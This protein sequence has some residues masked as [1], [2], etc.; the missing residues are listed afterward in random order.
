MPRSMLRSMRL[1]TLVVVRRGRSRATAFGLHPVVPRDAPPAL[2]LDEL[3]ASAT[4]HADFRS[5]RAMR[6]RATNQS[7]RSD[8]VCS[9]REPGAA[10]DCRFDE[11]GTAIKASTDA[12][13][14]RLVSEAAAGVW[15]GFR[16]DRRERSK[17]AGRGGRRP[18]RR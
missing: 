1:D 7:G 13:D 5:A 6:E 11:V 8:V 18:R 10:G 2:A 16:A 14:A 17:G 4:R 12:R 3:G 9:G 15:R